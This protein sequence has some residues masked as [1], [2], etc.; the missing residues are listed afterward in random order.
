MIMNHANTK[1][2]A[3]PMSRLSRAFRT[4]GGAMDRQQPLSNTPAN[5]NPVER[6]VSRRVSKRLPAQMEGHELTTTNISQSGLQVQVTCPQ[7]WRQSIQQAW[8][9][10]ATAVQIRLPTDDIV[11]FECSV[12]Y[13]SECDDEYLIGLKFNDPKDG[14]RE[15]WHS[16]LTQLYGADDIDSA[17][18]AA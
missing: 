17:A 9:R 3:S 12:A 16:Y 2:I 1:G 8:D 4:I 6:R 10:T 13:E 5:N 15:P 11:R 7:S 14:E 18:S